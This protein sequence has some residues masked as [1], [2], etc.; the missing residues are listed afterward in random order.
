[1]V[2]YSLSGYWDTAAVL[3]R[4][5]APVLG[6]TSAKCKCEH[7]VMSLDLEVWTW[8]VAGSRTVHTRSDLA[9]IQV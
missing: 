7:I 6:I 4:I 9:V 5:L 2:G 1:M 3:L 8:F